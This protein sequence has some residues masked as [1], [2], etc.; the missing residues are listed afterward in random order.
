MAHVVKD[1]RI[2]DTRPIGSIS[3]WLVANDKFLSGWG[4]APNRSLVAYPVDE[5]SYE[6]F[7]KLFSFCNMRSDFVYVRVQ[8][9]LPR[10]YD[11][12]HLSIYDVP[13]RFVDEESA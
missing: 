11:G 8:G 12:D 9:K 5:L 1:S 7:N 3:K 4:C 6:S 13:G 2:F 10:M